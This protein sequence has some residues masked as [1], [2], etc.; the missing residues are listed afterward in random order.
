VAAEL[1]RSHPAIV[2]EFE[3]GL[4]PWVGRAIIA[5]IVCFGLAS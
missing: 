5:A 3:G 1:V 4:V 2:E